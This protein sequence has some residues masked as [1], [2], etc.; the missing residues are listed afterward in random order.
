MMRFTLSGFTLV[1]HFF[2]YAVFGQITAVPY[3]PSPFATIGYITG[4]LSL[5][6]TSYCVLA[7]NI[8]AP[9]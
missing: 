8:P 2:V 9:H 7:N 4:F 5:P 6:T 1:L 3:D